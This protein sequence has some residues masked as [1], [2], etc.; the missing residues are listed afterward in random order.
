MW[1]AIARWRGHFFPSK[2]S[3]TGEVWN[4]GQLPNK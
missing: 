3:A 4:A 2:K 1:L